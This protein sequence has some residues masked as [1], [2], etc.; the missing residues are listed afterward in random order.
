MR[1]SFGAVIFVGFTKGVGLAFISLIYI[2]KCCS[3]LHRNKHINLLSNETMLVQLVSY[4]HETETYHLWFGM[5]NFEDSFLVR[6]PFLLDHVFS[7][8]SPT[9]C[10]T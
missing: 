4:F 9:S 7:M 6:I 2:L 1:T 3:F 5:L 8:H 10:L